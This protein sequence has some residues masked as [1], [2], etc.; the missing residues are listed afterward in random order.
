[1]W[2]PY[3][4]GATN[5]NT[6]NND[7][8][9]KHL[10]I[11]IYIYIFL[12]IATAAAPGPGAWEQMI[13]IMIMIMANVMNDDHYSTAIDY[14]NYTSSYSYNSCNLDN[15]HLNKQQQTNEQKQTFNNDNSCSI[16][17]FRVQ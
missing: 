8:T 10:L 1:M 9:N 13:M 7:N 5:I 15:Q 16:F 4:S 2:S 17:V 6:D 11:Y 12:V 14:S 3:S